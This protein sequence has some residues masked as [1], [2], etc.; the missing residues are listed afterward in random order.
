M[1]SFNYKRVDLSIASLN[2]RNIDN[3]SDASRPLPDVVAWLRDA[4][5][6]LFK[7]FVLMRVIWSLVSLTPQ[8][9]VTQ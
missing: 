5:R 4:I 3:T 1:D 2:E 7:P 8:E 9:L 6:A